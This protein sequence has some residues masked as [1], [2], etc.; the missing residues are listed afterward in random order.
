MLDRVLGGSRVDDG[1]LGAVDDE[2]RDLDARAPTRTI[3]ATPE[4]PSR[5]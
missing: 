2:R 4:S 5:R 3:D 1:V